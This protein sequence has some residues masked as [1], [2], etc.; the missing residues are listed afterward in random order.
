LWFQKGDV[1]KDG[2]ITADE[3][4]NWESRMRKCDIIFEFEEEAFFDEGD[5]DNDGFLSKG[6]HYAEVSHLNH[7]GEE[8]D[9]YVSNEVDTYFDMMDSNDDGKLSSEELKKGF[10]VLR[11]QCAA[12]LTAFHAINHHDNRCFKLEEGHT[13]EEIKD[14]VR[15]VG[16]QI[17]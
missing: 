3:F 2:T 1:N 10:E 12:V 6:E 7:G 4:N 9:S 15:A 11:N 17:M 5:R 13:L 16:N 8:M 14:C